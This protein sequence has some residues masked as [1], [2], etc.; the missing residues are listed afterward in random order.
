MTI[1]KGILRFLSILLY[2][3][4]MIACIPFAAMEVSAAVGNLTVTIDTGATV[5]L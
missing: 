5:T 2:I 4:L 1:H 3:C